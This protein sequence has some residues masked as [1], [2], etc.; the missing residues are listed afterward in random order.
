MEVDLEQEMLNK[1]PMVLL[2]Q[3]VLLLPGRWSRPIPYSR[4]FWVLC[5][6]SGDTV[7]VVSV[8]RG[9]VEEAAVGPQAVRV[10]EEA[11]DPQE[12]RVDPGRED[13]EGAG[14]SQMDWQ[15]HASLCQ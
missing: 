4:H 8:V 6:P 15:K 11:A 3:L 14:G 2:E 10:V 13:H 5:M 9:L 7:E 1:V 12:D